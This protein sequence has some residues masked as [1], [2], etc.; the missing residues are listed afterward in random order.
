MPTYLR[1]LDNPSR[2]ARGLSAHLLSFFP[3][4]APQA[5]PVITA[6]LAAEPDRVVASFL[7]LTAGTIGDPADTGLAAAVT[8]WRDQPGRL[9]RWT[10]LMGLARL[11]ATPDTDMLEQLCDCLFHGPANFDGWTFHHDD[12]ALGA[13]LALGD[14]P[15][16][17]VPALG[18]ML[19]ER[20]AAGGE[21]MSRFYYAARLLL[22]L[23]FPDGPPP[24]GA[25]L[26]PGQ[27]AAADVILHSGL[28]EHPSIGRLLQECQLP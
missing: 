6:R 21:D 10:V 22:S 1:L 9:I 28:A 4:A 20:L 26:S 8:R 7:C 14:L 16:R 13:A 25:D 3:G 5:T 27:H 2:D 19:I 18:P 15:A 23:A 24:A 11:T 12:P 17:S